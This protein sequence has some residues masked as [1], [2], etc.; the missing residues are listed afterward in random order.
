MKSKVKSG[1]STR[2]RFYFFEDR[3]T[4]ACNFETNFATIV[5]KDMKSKIKTRALSK[6]R[7]LRQKDRAIEQNMKSR[8]FAVA[9]LTVFG[10][11]RADLTVDKPPDGAKKSK[12]KSATMNV[13]NEKE[14]KDAERP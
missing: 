3:L 5:P 14:W 11:K 10:V 1:R 9:N 12:N 6:S 13:G 8:I 4:D 2:Q 7:S